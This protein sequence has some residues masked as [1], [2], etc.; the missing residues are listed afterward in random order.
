MGKY[1]KPEIIDGLIESVPYEEVLR[2]Y[3]YRI[4]GTGKNRGSNCP[5]CGK[6]HNHFKINTHRNTAN[7]FVCS[8]SGNPIQFIQELEGLGFLDAVEK[9]AE[10]GNYPLPQYEGK[11]RTFTVKEKILYHTIQFYKQ[12]AHKAA[13]YLIK[14]GISEKVIQDYQIGYAPGG[15][16]LKEYLNS[17]SFSDEELIDAGIIVERNGELK[18]FY[19]HSVI[20]PII[21]N[22]I[23]IDIYGRYAAKE[24]KTKHIYLYGD[25]IPFNIDNLRNDI[26]VIPVESI[27]N[28]L[29]LI[30]NG[31]TNVFAAGG[32]TKFTKRHARQLRA[33]NINKAYIGYDTG[34]ISMAGQKGAIEAGKLLQEIGIETFIIQM[35][36]GTDINELFINYPNPLE[37]LKILIK[38]A[39]PIKEYELKF[40]LDNTQIEWIERYL[41]LRKI[42]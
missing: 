24:A 37:E 35:P 28:A 2:F 27:I 22:G 15:S 21:Y 40:L 34:D 3:N 36:E 14:R 4:K 30:T 8:W 7:C 18:D 19:Y 33:K 13:A 10:I 5:R 17:L 29:T 1:Y 42:N 31:I 20:V 23:I 26:P 9:Y 11:N 16:K 39:M 25:H 38:N 32:T 6:D 41:E 12:Y